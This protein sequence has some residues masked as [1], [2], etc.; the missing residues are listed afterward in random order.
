MPNHLPRRHA[1]GASGA[2]G[3]LFNQPLRC[4]FWRWKS[5][6]KN[7][8][9]PV[10]APESECI[11]MAPQKGRYP[12]KVGPPWTKS[13]SW[14]TSLGASNLG[15]CICGG[16]PEGPWLVK[17]MVKD[18][19]NLWKKVNLNPQSYFN[20]MK[21]PL[22]SQKII[23]SRFCST[24]RWSLPTWD[25]LSH[26]GWGFRAPSIC[27]FHSAGVRFTRKS[28]YLAGAMTALHV[29][30]NDVILMHFGVLAKPQEPSFVHQGF[31]A[32]RWK[33]RTK[34]QSAFVELRRFSWVYFRK[35]HNSS[36][37]MISSMH[38]SKWCF[39]LRYLSFKGQR[40]EVLIQGLATRSSASSFAKLVYA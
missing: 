38:Y 1:R 4:A 17:S 2:S 23:I 12:Y 7:R 10:D 14:G 28:L 33:D 15:G 20:P 31:L 13:R 36:S 3:R 19:P 29:G 34:T 26:G 21:S 6:Q 35:L 40:I 32:T 39:K 30:W 18:I 16:Q 24:F 8:L 22:K 37:S 5:Q 27:S 25:S 9:F 11:K